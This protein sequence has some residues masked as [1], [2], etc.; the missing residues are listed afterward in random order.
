MAKGNKNGTKAYWRKDTKGKYFRALK[1]FY[2]VN[3]SI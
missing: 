3:K 1:E 2:K